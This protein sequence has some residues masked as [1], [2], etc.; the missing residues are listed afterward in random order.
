MAARAPATSISQRRASTRL[1]RTITSA[2]QFS[3][4][5]TTTGIGN[6]PTLLG[7]A[8]NTIKRAIAATQARHSSL[9][10]SPTH[11]QRV[12]WDRDN[13]SYQSLRVLLPRVLPRPN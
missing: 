3:S 9:F 13:Y 12:Q 11:R 10:L 1:R 7:P 6:S 8:L 5:V 2:T 4:A